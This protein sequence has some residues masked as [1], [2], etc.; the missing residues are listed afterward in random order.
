M[1]V[2]VG[3]QVAERQHDPARVGG[4]RGQVGIEVG[5]EVEHDV[6][7]PAAAEERIASLIDQPRQLDRRSIDR[8]VARLDLGH[9]A[10]VAGQLL[11]AVGL[12]VDDPHVLPGLSRPTQG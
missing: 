1:L 11:Q 8:Q 5:I 9:V 4:D 10:Q 3:E 6:V 7:T 12:G 2:R